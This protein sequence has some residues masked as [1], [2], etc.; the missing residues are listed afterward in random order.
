MSISSE[1]RAI[2]GGAVLDTIIPDSTG[3]DMHEA[4]DLFQEV[5]RDTFQKDIS[6]RQR[7]HVFFGKET[8]FVKNLSYLTYLQMCR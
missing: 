4:V 1:D 8:A 3:S 2:F 7:R 6:P 5:H